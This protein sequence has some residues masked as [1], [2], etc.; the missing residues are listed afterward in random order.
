MNLNDII[1]AIAIQRKLLSSQQAIL[2]AISGIDASGKGY[3]AAQ[4]VK[5][6]SQGNLRVASI[7]V[8]GW[9]IP[10]RDGQVC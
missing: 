3:I 5:I 10:F 6:L 2:V 1:D 9:L 4:I 7:N 8:D